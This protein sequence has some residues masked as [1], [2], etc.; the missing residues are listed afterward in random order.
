MADTAPI[1][2]TMRG[3]VVADA[4][5]SWAA[6][7]QTF[8]QQH[9][10]RLPRLLDQPVIAYVRAKVAECSG[11][12]INTVRGEESH[13]HFFTS[14]ELRAGPEHPVNNLFW[15]LLSQRH[16][17]QAVD[18]ICGCDGQL[19]RMTGR[20]MELHPN[21]EQFIDWHDDGLPGRRLGFSIDLS[22]QP[23]AGGQFQLRHA[24]TKR[25]YARVDSQ[26]GDCHL[27]RIHPSLEHR[28]TPLT[29]TTP[30]CCYAGWFLG[31]KQRGAWPAHL[32]QVRLVRR[33]RIAG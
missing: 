32:P 21:T 29:G 23:F 1:K 26:L 7:R 5:D 22:P 28:V 13:E 16:F 19:R 30:R 20:Y 6:H 2:L 12:H 25:M 11:F 15:I 14:Q 3:T 8:R 31:S 27:F 10:V 18:D 24:K 17:L 9:C 4:A 33:S